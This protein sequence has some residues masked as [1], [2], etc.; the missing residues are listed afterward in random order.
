[1]DAHRDDTPA[2]GWLTSLTRMLRNFSPFLTYIVLG[3][4]VYL[5]WR[6]A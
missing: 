6:G 5:L 3:L 4:L 1:M 2:E